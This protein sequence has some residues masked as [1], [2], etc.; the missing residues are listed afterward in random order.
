[1]HRRHPK[2]LEREGEEPERGPAAPEGEPEHRLPTAGTLSDTEPGELPVVDPGLSVEPEDLGRQFMRDATE[3]DNFESSLDLGQIGRDREA[4][5]ADQIVSEA[6]LEAAGQEDADV[7]ESTALSHGPREDEEIEP[8]DEVD[9]L[10][11]TIDEGSV[12]DRVT[13]RGGTTAPAA[14]TDDS[15]GMH[16]HRPPGTDTDAREEEER[17]TWATLQHGRPIAARKPPP[18]EG[19]RNR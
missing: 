7:P 5:G 9:V 1:M 13:S 19:S 16:T 4:I 11:N 15:S 18:G 17:S 8:P 3:Q 14:K 6:T 12:F 10:S 2:D